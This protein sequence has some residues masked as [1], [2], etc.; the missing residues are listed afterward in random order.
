MAVGKITRPHGLKGEV[1]VLPFLSNRELLKELPRFFL[2]KEGEEILI[3]ISVREAPGGRDFLFRFEGIEDVEIAEGLRGR[4]LYAE[5]SDFPELEEGEFYY[6]QIEDL[7]V[8][9]EAGEILGRVKGV[10]PVGPYDLLEVE[11]KEGQSF[12]L[13]MVEEVILEINLDEGYVL[14]RP[15]PGLIE[16][17]I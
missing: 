9:T 16:S 14:V 4:V 2:Q 17:Q 6:F 7:P 10:M 8:K 15:T 1:R 13:P 3:P 5:V 12:Y 11:T